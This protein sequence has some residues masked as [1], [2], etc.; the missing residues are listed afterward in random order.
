MLLPGTFDCL[1]RRGKEFMLL[2][3]KMCKN[4]EFSDRSKLLP[5]RM[6]LRIIDSRFSIRRVSLLEVSWAF[7]AAEYRM[8]SFPKMFWRS[9]GTL[10]R[11]INIRL[12]WFVTTIRPIQYDYILYHEYRSQEFPYVPQDML[13]WQHF[14]LS[15]RS[16]G[17]C[18]Y[19]KRTLWIVSMRSGLS[20][21]NCVRSICFQTEL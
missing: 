5:P 6:L 1:K 21:A 4:P 3:Y 14:I 2:D 7:V 9:I 15:P 19:E 8:L 20:F 11:I 12:T 13:V 17:Y 10:L 18:S 16:C